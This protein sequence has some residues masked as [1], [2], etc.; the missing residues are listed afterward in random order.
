M[1]EAV[2]GKSTASGFG[3]SIKSREHLIGQKY[4]GQDESFIW[5]FSWERDTVTNGTY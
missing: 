2:I 5:S 1:S 4:V 3:W